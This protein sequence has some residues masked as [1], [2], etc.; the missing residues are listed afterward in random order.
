MTRL[1]A[2]LVSWAVAIRNQLRS[3]SVRR[4]RPHAQAKLAASRRPMSTN[5]SHRMPRSCGR[6]ENRS[7]SCG[8]TKYRPTMATAKMMMRRRGRRFS[9]PRGVEK[10]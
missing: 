3:F 9:N 8:Q 4:M 2:L 1:M 7:T 10:P 6:C 5:H